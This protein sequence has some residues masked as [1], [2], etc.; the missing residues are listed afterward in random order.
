MLPSADVIV[1]ATT[2]TT[3]E[4]NQTSTRETI[5]HHPTANL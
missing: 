3:T 5:E 1:P 4:Q 2:A